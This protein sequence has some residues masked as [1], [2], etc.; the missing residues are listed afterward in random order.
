MA[1]SVHAAP[2]GDD[3]EGQERRSRRHEARQKRAGGD[4]VGWIGDRERRRHQAVEDEIEHDVEITV[5]VGPRRRARHRTVEAV[6]QPVERDEAEADDRVT[7]RHSQCRAAADEKSEPR[8][9][10]GG[11][12]APAQVLSGAIQDRGHRTH[13]DRVKHLILLWVRVG[14]TADQT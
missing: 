7:V 1:G 11:P 6:A 8:D 3:G 14:R 10:I 13:Q 2:G 9:A 12:A 4:C 5:K